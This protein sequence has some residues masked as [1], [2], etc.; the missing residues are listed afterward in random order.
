MQQNGKKAKEVNTFASHCIQYGYALKDEVWFVE[1]TETTY[2]KLGCC[3]G[4]DVGGA[5]S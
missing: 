5:A 1:T 4:G 2:I 3:C